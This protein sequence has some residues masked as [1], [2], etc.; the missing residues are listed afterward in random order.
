MQERPFYF[1]LSIFKF[2]VEKL[3]KLY[4]TKVFHKSNCTSYF[5][6]TKNH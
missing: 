2:L 3:Q 6:V 1:K 5:Y 4:G